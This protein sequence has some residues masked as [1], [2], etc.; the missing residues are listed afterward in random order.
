MTY[1]AA[2]PLALVT[3]VGPGTG[4]AIARCFAEGGCRVATLARKWFPDAAED[5]F[6]Q[7]ASIAEAV[8]RLAHQPRD[9]WSFF[10]EVRR[11][12]EPW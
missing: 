11:F 1:P 10:A 2:K 3:G 4:S 9:A 12:H 8:Y 5:F 7:P 6:I